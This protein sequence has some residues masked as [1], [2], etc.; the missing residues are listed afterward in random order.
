[1]KFAGLMAHVAVQ[2]LPTQA[3]FDSE[4]HDEEA[5]V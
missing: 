1:M 4:E 2:T 3:K 5:Q